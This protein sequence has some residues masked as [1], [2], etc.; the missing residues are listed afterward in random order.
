MMPGTSTHRG[1][2]SLSPVHRHSAAP[3]FP[4]KVFVVDDD[5]AVRAAVSMLVRTCGWEAVPCEDAEDFLRRY[6][7]REKQCLVVDLRMPGL[8]GVQLQRKL[9]ARGDDLPVIVVTAHHDLP[10]ADEAY[11]MGARAVLGKPFK[12]ED[13]LQRIRAALELD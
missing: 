2:V 6:E 12:D 3:R 8:S 1:F 7:P 11:T 5:S 4:A 10:E 13:L 9:R